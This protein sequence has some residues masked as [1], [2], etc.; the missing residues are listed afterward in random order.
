[1][2]E[3]FR[4]L[5]LLLLCLGHGYTVLRPGEDAIKERLPWGQVREYSVESL[6]AGHSYEVLISKPSTRPASFRLWMK[7]ESEGTGR[8]L[9]D[10]DKLVWIAEETRVIVMVEATDDGVP[11]GLEKEAV[12]SIRVNLNLIHGVP[13]LV[14]WNV[15]AVLG[16][17]GE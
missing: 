11:K 8:K 5:L 10:T 16:L 1:M 2:E 7:G 3:G 17:S 6:I 4:L 15:L 12:Y 14:I 13:F 9:L